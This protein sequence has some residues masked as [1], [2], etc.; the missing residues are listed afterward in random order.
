MGPH[1][2]FLFTTAAEEP[3]TRRQTTL[4]MTTRRFWKPDAGS[5]EQKSTRVQGA[6]GP[7]RRRF[8]NLIMDAKDAHMA[9][10][11]MGNARFKSGLSAS[12]HSYKPEEETSR[13]PVFYLSAAL[14][15]PTTNTFSPAVHICIFGALRARSAGATKA[16]P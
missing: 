14:E 1:T 15:G 5:K 13:L 9:H 7:R 3:R 10:G 4:N 8:A 16:A 12:Y 6:I 11:R 2:R